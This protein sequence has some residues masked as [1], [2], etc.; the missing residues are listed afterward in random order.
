MPDRSVWWPACLNGLWSSLAHHFRLKREISSRGVSGKRRPESSNKAV[1]KWLFRQ[2]FKKLTNISNAA[3]SG[4]VLCIKRSFIVEF[5]RSFLLLHFFKNSFDLS[6]WGFASFSSDKGTQA[7]FFSYYTLIYLCCPPDCVWNL[8]AEIF[9]AFYYFVSSPFILSTL[10][11]R[12]SPVLYKRWLI[13]SQP[14]VQRIICGQL[15]GVISQHNRL[16]SLNT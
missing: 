5:L 15:V 1:G 14:M 8:L 4:H 7:W 2:F 10:S 13:N 12:K 11:H 3:H 9:V 6:L 16:A